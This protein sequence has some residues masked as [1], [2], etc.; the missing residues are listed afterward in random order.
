MHVVQRQHCDTDNKHE[1]DAIHTPYIFKKNAMSLQTLVHVTD[2]AA[3]N[4]V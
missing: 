4:A 1:Q 3:T 2:G